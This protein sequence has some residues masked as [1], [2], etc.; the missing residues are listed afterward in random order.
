MFDIITRKYDIQGSLIE[1]KT[2]D[3]GASME[4]KLAD[5][6]NVM[7]HYI[8][9]S[10]SG[11]ELKNCLS[12]STRK[13]SIARHEPQDTLSLIGNILQRLTDTN[14]TSQSVLIMTALLEMK[15]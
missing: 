13:S 11:I 5:D 15:R 4:E 8:E 14:E 10:S 6:I 1:R 7:F 9:G 2:R 3:N 12:K